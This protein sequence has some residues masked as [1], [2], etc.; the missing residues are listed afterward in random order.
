M[1]DA[2]TRARISKRERQRRWRQRNIQDRNSRI[3]TSVVAHL[4][5]LEVAVL[6]MMAIEDYYRRPVGRTEAADLTPPS[7]SR[8][9]RLL[10]RRAIDAGLVKVEDLGPLMA[11]RGE[12]GK[13]W[14][15]ETTWRRA[16]RDR[17]SNIDAK[18]EDWIDQPTP[19]WADLPDFQKPAEPPQRPL[20]QGDFLEAVEEDD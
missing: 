8:A 9:I 6:D 14:V 5:D 11:M 13:F 18:A 1:D 4:N 7:R 17:R 16:S 20:R 3:G 12:I 19:P 10:I 2:A 15:V